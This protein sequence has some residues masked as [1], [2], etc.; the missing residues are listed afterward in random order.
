M[1]VDISIGYWPLF[2][3]EY[4]DVANGPKAGY[5]QRNSQPD[6]DSLSGL[7]TSPPIS[8]NLARHMTSLGVLVMKLVS[9]RILDCFGFCDSGAVNLRDDS[10]L[11]YLLGRN[12]TGKSAFLDA[13]H[14]LGVNRTPEKDARFRNFNGKGK[15]GALIAQFDVD[16][17]DLPFMVF[18]DEVL[19]RFITSPSV[20]PYL[21]QNGEY[22]AKVRGIVDTVQPLLES[23]HEDALKA[24]QI[25]VC[26]SGDGHY[27]FGTDDTFSQH[28]TILSTLRDAV[29]RAFPDGFLQEAGGSRHGVSITAEQIIDRLFVSFSKIIR[30]ED[31]Y[32]LSDDLPDSVSEAAA[33]DGSARGPLLHAL[34]T[35]LGVEQVRQFLNS[36]SPTLQDSLLR[37]MNKA[38]RELTNEVNK[39]AAG[40]ATDVM[41]MLLHTSVG[42]GL[43]ITVVTGTKESFYSQ[44]SRNT[45]FLFA[46]YL[47]HAAYG[48][49]NAVLLFDEPNNGFHAT[50]QVQLL[51]F[52]QALGCE[53]NL[54]VVSTHSEYMIDPD[55]LT[56]IRL[57]GVDKDTNTL[58]VRNHYYTSDNQENAGDNLALQPIVDALGLKY[59][60][61]K[62]TIHD[63]VIVTEGITD[64]LYL[65]SLNE[66]LF[67]GD[68]DLHVAP[69]QGDSRLLP[70]VALLISQGL[71]FKL[72]MDISNHSN[73]AKIRI[74]TSYGIDDRFFKTIPIPPAFPANR[75]SGIEDLFSKPDFRKLLAASCWQAG[76]DFESMSNGEYLKQRQYHSRKR[77]T[78]AWLHEHIGQYDVSDFDEETI[79][80]FKD[81]LSFCHSE[82]WFRM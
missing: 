59:G 74:R 46:Y 69:G 29:A 47:Y 3:F 22:K 64:M 36:D 5:W 31:E 37:D 43:Q 80:N 2:R 68:P 15:P 73:D 65:R 14:A 6:D 50:A 8:R 55:Y 1:M 75:G 54:V 52:L 39:F 24:G 62:L 28:S 53:G 23:L 27:R 72:V 63:K 7:D 79:R 77:I 58:T 71:R 18:M 66:L 48:I 26:K 81:V 57:M 13:L 56:G 78:A 16:T 17:N 11:I 33:S 19:A 76:A 32:S 4:S 82:E 12:S 70:I 21:S 34:L 30:F 35:Y 25:L 41:T 51:D 10:H 42:A 9:F 38:I 44:I 20:D 67:D 60:L 61:G 45:K 49:R 40:G